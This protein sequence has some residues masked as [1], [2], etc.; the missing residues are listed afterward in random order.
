[1]NFDKYTH[2]V[3]NHMSICRL[4]EIRPS[5]LKLFNYLFDYCIKV[6]RDAALSKIKIKHSKTSNTPV[7]YLFIIN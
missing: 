7:K 5:G 1:M 4:C 3:A 2:P 6:C